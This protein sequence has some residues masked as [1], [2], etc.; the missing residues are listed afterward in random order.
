MTRNRCIKAPFFENETLLDVSPTAKLLLIYLLRFADREGKTE[1]RPVLFKREIYPAG[2][3]EILPLLSELEMAGE[4]IR[5]AAGDK[6]LIK[7]PRFRDYQKINSRE[8]GSVYPEPAQ[9]E[10]IHSAHGAAVQNI[11]PSH[12]KEG[13]GR[14]PG[15]FQTGSGTLPEPDFSHPYSLL[16]SNINNNIYINN[17]ENLQ[18]L[19]HAQNRGRDFEQMFLSFWGAFPK[20]VAKKDAMKAFKALKPDGELLSAMLS[21]IEKSKKSGKWDDAQF[22][23]YPATW[24]RGER[25]KDET[26][27]AYSETQ[28]AVVSSFNACLGEKLPE[29]EISLFNPARASR[30]DVFLTFEDGKADFYESY[31][32]WVAQNCELPPNVG[33]DYVISRDGYGKIKS[34]Q[35]CPVEQ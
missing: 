31:F 34:G 21:A 29:A 3:L 10:E 24:L 22:I 9:G 35:F 27:D 11:A 1:E 19:K 7:I 18:H 30:I 25:W 28:K 33:F 32:R 26:A 2:E 14:V 20:K 5:Y 17:E 16:T 13:S 8:P 6:R 15:G 12:A 23:P 4:I